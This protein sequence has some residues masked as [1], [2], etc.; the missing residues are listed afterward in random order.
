MSSIATALLPVFGV[1][2][3]GWLLRRSGLLPDSSW[4]PISRLA[5]LGLSPA[6]LFTSIAR[7]DLSSIQLGPFMLAAVGGFLGMAAITLA[8]RPLLNIPGPTY[9]SLFQATCR[10]NGLLILAIAISM[11]GTEGEVLVALIMAAS[12]PLVNME[13][14]AALSVWGDGAKPDWRSVIYRILTNPLILGSGAGGLVNLLDIPI[15]EPAWNTIHLL[16]Q[17]ALPLILLAVGAGLNFTAMK[18]RPRLLGLSV[19]LKL[20]IAPLVFYGLGLALGVEGVA[21]TVLLLTGA[22]PGAASAYVLAKQM[23]GDAPYSAGDITA[24]ALF[25]FITIPF[26]LWLLG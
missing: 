7:A 11:F 18:A 17:A 13:C 12:I 5:Y 1:I 25:C 9:T 24:S 22:S 4:G 2:F 26:W 10:W 15:P 21:L 20:I 19:F 16:G 23:G 3:V 6:I 14:V 8:I